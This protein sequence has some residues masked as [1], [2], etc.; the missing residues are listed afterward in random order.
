[1]ELFHQINREILKR[2]LPIFREKKLSVVELSVLM[3]L[4]RQQICYATELARMVGIPTSTVTGI[5][6]EPE[7]LQESMR[8]QILGI[9]VDNR[10]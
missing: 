8:A 7:N 2:L 3:R 5:L 4:N 9:A 1:M 6:H 10:A